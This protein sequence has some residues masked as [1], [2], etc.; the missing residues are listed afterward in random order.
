MYANITVTHVDTSTFA[1]FE[2][3]HLNIQAVHP[4]MCV[5][6]CVCVCVCIF[7]CVVRAYVHVGHTH[8]SGHSCSTG[9]QCPY[10]LP[11]PHTPLTERI[12]GL[13]ISGSV[14]L[15]V[16]ARLWG[17]VHSSL[18]APL[19]PASETASALWPTPA[20]CHPLQVEEQF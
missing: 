17:P 8:V 9:T 3:R 7:V 13:P 10:T 16:V 19:P 2:L 5:C 11:F 14:S 18:P 1:D 12:E 6:V 4:A 20:H 15:C